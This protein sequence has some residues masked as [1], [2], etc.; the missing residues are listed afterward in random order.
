M[1]GSSST[2]RMAQS[3]NIHHTVLQNGLTVVAVENAAADIVACRMLIKGGNRFERPG[4]AGVSNLMSAVLT[5][6]TD[7]LSSQDIAE[8]V[9]S[10]GASL[11]TDATTDY[12][13]VGLKTVASDFPAVLNLAAEIVRSPSFPDHEVD[14]ERRLTLQGIRSMREQ[15]FSVAYQN[16]RAILYGDHPYGGTGMGTEST[17]ATMTRDDLWDYYRDVFRPSE[18]VISI[19]GRI[20]PETAIAYVEDAFGDWNPPESGDRPALSFPMKSNSVPETIVDVQDTMQAIVMLGYPAAS[21]HSTDYA[22][23]KILSTHLGNGLSSRLFVELREKLGLAYDVSAIYPTR[24]DPS[25]FVVYIGTSPVNVETAM[26]GLQKEVDRMCH[27]ALTAGELQVAKNKLLGQYAL[28]KQTNAQIAQLYGWYEV[29]GL[30]VGFDQTFQE[31]VANLS[32]EEILDTAS[33]H[34]TAPPH[35][36]LVGPQ[37]AVS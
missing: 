16:L 21:V 8:K 11:G 5:K 34:F 19:T 36:S 9:E 15:P 28:G 31:T 13:L 17:V 22:A 1:A 26:N 23:L 27:Q 18:M 6:G 35:M 30:G 3:R 7:Y 14:L 33:R 25:H 32:A 24:I 12:C 10:I 4:K 29:L 37:D 20:A 2:L